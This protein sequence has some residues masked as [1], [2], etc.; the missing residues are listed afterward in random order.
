M[1]VPFALTKLQTAALVEGA[2]E[3]LEAEEVTVE[4]EDTPAGVE[5]SVEAT[6]VVGVV[7]VSFRGY[8]ICDTAR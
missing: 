6:M 8:I 4:V 2:E 3:A 1:V 5:A 7:M